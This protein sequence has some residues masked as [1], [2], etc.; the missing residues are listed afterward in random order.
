[1]RSRPIVPRRDEQGFALIIALFFAIVVLGLTV[2]GTAHMRSHRDMTRTSFV[3]HGQA[4][5]FA[6][7][8]LTE[9]LGWYRKQTAQPVITLDPRLDEL[10]VPPILETLEPDI[11]IVREFPITGS[12]WGRY[13]VWKAWP[14]DPDADRLFFRNQVQCADIS[15]ERGNLSPG[16]VWR[17]RS[18][19]YVFRRNDPLA[20]FDQQPNQVLG[21]EIVETEVRRLALQPP[22]QAALCLRNGSSCSVATRGR[23]LGGSTGTGVYHLMGTGSPSVSGSGASI[24]GVPPIAAAT[25]YSDDMIAVFG[26]DFAELRSMSDSNISNPAHFPSPVPAESLVVAETD[27][28]FDSSRPL[29]GTA[30]VVVRGNVTIGQGSNSS[31][32]GLLYVDGNLIVREPAEIQ[33]AV[34][35]TGTVLVQGS[36]DTATVTFDDGILNRLRQNMGTYRMSSAIVRPLALEGR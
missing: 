16:S 22:G 32:S 26:V 34:V 14:G 27:I 21:T 5:Q 2:T 4:L 36:A 11:G 15:A 29:A 17:V 3:S 12:L 33:G 20:V 25:I 13:E 18:V 23:I 10:A 24:T 19:G 28:T 9:A 7:S 30:V 1:M 8:G 35:V 31:F 6:R